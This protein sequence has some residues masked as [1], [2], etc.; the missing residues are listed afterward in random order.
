[1]SGSK[2]GSHA[3]EFPEK[4]LG[5]MRRNVGSVLLC[6][7]N[8]KKLGKSD[9]SECIFCTSCPLFKSILLVFLV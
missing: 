4:Y 1:M 9:V 5:P 6:E 8:S 7:A 3:R 2:Y